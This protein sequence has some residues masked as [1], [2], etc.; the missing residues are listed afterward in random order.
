MDLNNYY[1]DDEG[2]VDIAAVRHQYAGVTHVGSREFVK[3]TINQ[4]LILLDDLQRTR[5]RVAEIER[6]NEALLQ[7][8][9]RQEANA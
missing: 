5:E 7:T 1:A 3:N 2:R 9:A 6:W 4:I 8:L